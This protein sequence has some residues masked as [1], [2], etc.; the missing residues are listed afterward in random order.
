[1][2]TT[3]TSLLV[4]RRYAVSPGVAVVTSLLFAFLPYHFQRGIS[5]LWLAAY[6]MVPLACMIILETYLGATFFLRA[7]HK[8]PHRNVFNISFAALGAFVICV[9]IALAGTYY[10]V[11][12]CFFLLVAGIAAAVRSRLIRPVLSAVILIGLIGGTFLASHLPHFMI[13]F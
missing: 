10:A 6:Y 7:H 9:L 2:L 4:L 8:K 13:S 11:F 1:F 12:T 3:L 5:H